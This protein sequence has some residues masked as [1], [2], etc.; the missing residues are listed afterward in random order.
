M[1]E[2]GGAGV[3]KTADNPIA[4]ELLKAAKALEGKLDFSSNAGR[5][6]A[7]GEFVALVEG[8]V[9]LPQNR[10][11]KM[12]IG[13][14]IMANYAGKSAEEIM[15]VI[16]DK[17]GFANVKEEKAAAKEAAAEAACANPKNAGLILAL[18]ECS[19]VCTQH[20]AAMPPP[21]IYRFD[22][23]R[24]CLTYTRNHS[25]LPDQ[26]WSLIDSLAHSYTCFSTA[27]LFRREQ[28]Q[29]GSVVQKSYYDSHSTRRGGNR[30]Q[31]H[32]VLQGK[33]KA[34]RNR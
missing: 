10:N 18:G 16:F 29:C 33:N 4:Q 3:T 13:K 21:S 7:V 11:P 8:K 34:G 6:Q 1:R 31:C 28:H 27:V 19:K 25:F 9:D 17:Y 2:G 12:E 5:K 22:L 20:I 32:V 30:R 15:Q 26:F 14:L 24:H 23:P